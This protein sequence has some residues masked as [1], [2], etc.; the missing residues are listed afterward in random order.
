[1]RKQIN[2]ITWSGDSQLPFYHVLKQT[3]RKYWDRFLVDDK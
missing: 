2:I 1:M 3:S